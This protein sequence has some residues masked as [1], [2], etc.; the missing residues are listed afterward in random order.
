MENVELL[1]KEMSNIEYGWI[2][3]TGYKYINKIAKNKF[4]T[5]WYLQKPQEIKKTQIGICW[6]QVEYERNFFETHKIKH[7]CI[8]MIYEDGIKNPMHTFL[9]FKDKNKYY[10]FENTYNNVKGIISFDN[11][12]D[13]IEKVKYEFKKENALE[14][15]GEKLYL[16]VYEKPEYEISAEEFVNHCISS[17]K[18][19]NDLNNLDL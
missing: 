5:D 7:K 15:I 1:L 18:V 3:K 19:D 16:Y 17:L 6:D 14:E 4:I 13:C 11:L 9:I 2:D 8:F 10:W 12:K